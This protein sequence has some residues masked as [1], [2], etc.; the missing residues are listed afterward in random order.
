MADLGSEPLAGSVAD[1][2]KLVA[3]KLRSGLTSS[4]SPAS[5]RS[6]PLVGGKECHARSALGICRENV[7][8]CRYSRVARVPACGIVP[9]RLKRVRTGPS[10]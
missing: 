9:E 7:I 6:R 1:F 3:G 10:Y 8:L 5:R 4:N 2:A